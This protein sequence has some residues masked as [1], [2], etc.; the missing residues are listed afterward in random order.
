M[1][2]PAADLKTFHWIE[3]MMPG[4]PEVQEDNIPGGWLSYVIPPTYIAWFWYFF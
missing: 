3:D 2:F 1:L 4:A